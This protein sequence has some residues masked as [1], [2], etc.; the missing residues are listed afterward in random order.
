MKE[1]NVRTFGWGAL[2]ICQCGWPISLS[3]T[4]EIFSVYQYFHFQDAQVQTRLK[5]TKKKQLGV[6]V[7]MVS[8]SNIDVVKCN[9]QYTIVLIMII[10]N[11]G[12]TSS[13]L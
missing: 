4:A 9:E 7:S 3:E 12:I 8:L 5:I 2:H 6:F 1:Y 11:F 10:T 13:L